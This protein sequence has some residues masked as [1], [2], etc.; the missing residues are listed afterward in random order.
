MHLFKEYE[1]QGFKIDNVWHIFTLQYMFLSGIQGELNAFKLHWN[2]HPLDNEGNYSPLQ[3]IE[4]IILIM[5]IL[6]I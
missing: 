1:R 5:K 3:L 6:L 4:I 2:N